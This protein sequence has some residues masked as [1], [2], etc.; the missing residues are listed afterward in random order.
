MAVRISS[1]SSSSSSWL[2]IFTLLPRDSEEMLHY[3]RR[4]I[5]TAIP[6]APLLSSPPSSS[7]SRI[8]TSISSSSPS[9]SFSLSFSSRCHSTISQTTASCLASTTPFASDSFFADED[10]TW[11]SLG[12]TQDLIDALERTSFS[13]PS[14]VQVSFFFLFELIYMH[15]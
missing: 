15:P 13:R 14:A 1:S 9:C 12:L 7:F 6:S 10:V 4:C 2:A 3:S 5:R 11:K 8:S